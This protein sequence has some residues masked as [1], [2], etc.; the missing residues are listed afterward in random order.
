LEKE[1]AAAL[2]GALAGRGLTIAANV[3]QEYARKANLAEQL[4]QA[5]AGEVQAVLEVFDARGYLEAIKQRAQGARAG[6]WV[7]PRFETVPLRDSV[8]E[9]VF[10]N[11]HDGTSAY[12]MLISVCH[13]P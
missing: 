3:L 4:A 10:L 7:A 5:I 13:Y 2:L 1:T 6:Q 11:S 8:P 9:I 12:L